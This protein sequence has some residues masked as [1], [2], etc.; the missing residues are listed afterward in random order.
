VETLSAA[1]RGDLTAARA[2]LDVYDGE[3]NGIEVYVNTR[4]RAL[5]GEIESH[6]QADVSAALDAAQ[7]DRATIVGLLQAMIGQYDEAIKLSDSGP[8]LH[9]LFDDVAAVRTVRAPLRRV[10]P[11][12]RAGDPGRATT[13]FAAF[14]GRWGEVQPLFM[15]RSSDLTRQTQAAFDAAD[16]A[17]AG[18]MADPSAAAALV[19][20]L[21]DRY[22]VGVNALSA[23]ARN[24]DVG[25][26]TFGADDVQ[27]T[28]QVG[29]IEREVRASLNA[30]AAGDRAVAS[31]GARNA[32]EVR[33][34]AAAAAL[35]TRGGMDAAVKKALEAYAGA[36]DASGDAA[37]SAGQAALDAV[38]T[39]EQ[40]V[41][42]QFWTDPA[43]QTAYRAALAAL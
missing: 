10:S 1:Q 16:G 17:L 13:N 39:A 3:W 4:S 41:G 22:N 9:P 14:K 33:F 27:A 21:M 11:A 34:G 8:P 28:A 37:S 12:L 42:G 29:A 7:P 40:A 25:K 30:L 26:T 19:D 43:F 18:G 6:Y 24:A 20:V 38:F 15:A 5:Y 23:A 2:A 35:G 32:L 36:L 31:T